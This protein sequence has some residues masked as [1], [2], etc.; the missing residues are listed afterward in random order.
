MAKCIRGCKRMSPIRDQLV[1]MIDCLPEQEQVLVFEIVKRFVP[2][3]V[4]T[5]DDL[6][7]IQEAREEYAQGETVN[8]NDINWN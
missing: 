8:H 2:D 6:R 5:P 3:D 4:A 7:A 1:E